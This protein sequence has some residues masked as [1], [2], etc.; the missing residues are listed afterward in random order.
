MVRIKVIVPFKWIDKTGVV[1]LL[2][3]IERKQLVHIRTVGLGHIAI[4][5][6]NTSHLG[7]RNTR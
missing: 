7:K 4:E 5:R 6:D 1:N 3:T 2:V